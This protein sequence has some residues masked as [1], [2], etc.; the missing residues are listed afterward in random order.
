MANADQL[1]K[2][3]IIVR[4]EAVDS[5]IIGE[6]PREGIGAALLR[7]LRNSR[8]LCTIYS[9]PVA[10]TQLHAKHIFAVAVRMKPAGYFDIHYAPA[11]R[12]SPARLRSEAACR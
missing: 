8:I 7:L 5:R 2:H 11:Y 4:A 12:E 3:S 6:M 10:D 9:F 1:G